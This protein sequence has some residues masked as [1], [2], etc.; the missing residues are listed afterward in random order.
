MQGRAIF[1]AITSIYFGITGP[2]YALLVSRS[3]KG[4]ET[5][6]FVFFK[7]YIIILGAYIAFNYLSN[8]FVRTGRRMATR[9]FQKHMYSSNMEL[10]LKSDNNQIE[11]LGTGQ[12]NSI[13]Q[14][15]INN[16]QWIVF[17]NLLGNGIVII[18]TIVLTFIIIILNLWRVI[19]TIVLAVFI[20][21]ITIARAG[22][23]HMKILRRERRDIMIK[24][25]RNFIRLIMSKFEILQNSRVAKEVHK[26]IDFSNQLM[27]RDKKESKWFIVASDIP[28][29]LID[30][31]KRVLLVWYGFQIFWWHWSIAEFT[32]IW[33]LMNQ[34]TGVLFNAN[35]LMLSY[36]DQIT[37]LQKLRSTFDWIPKLKWYETGKQFRFSNGEIV[38]DDVYFNYG[39]KNVFQWFSL[40][41]QW[42][43]KTAFVG[44]S[45]SGKTTLL[46]LISWYVHPDQ[47][48]VIIDGQKLSTVAL[49]DYYG[50]IWYLTQDPNVFDGSVR[51]NLLYGTSKKPTKKQIDDAIKLSRCEFIYTFKDGLETQI[52][53]KWIRLSWGQKQRLAIAKLF[54]KNPKIIFLDEPTSSLDSFSEED[55]SLAIGDLFKWR[56]VIVV[57]HRLQTVKQANIIH[58]LNKAGQIV[59]S[60]NHEELL[61]KKWLYFKMLELQS[62]F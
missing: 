31:I 17:E 14:K 21:M 2:L 54:L 28:R 58:V 16:R 37:F 5:K 47:W 32:L 51:D 60:G 20:I 46:K 13:I 59:E 23:Q 18:A 43:K 61:K 36:Y 8:Y 45:G 12:A 22:N 38:L 41:I 40:K 25:D 11:T 57:A 39:E 26:I 48:A 27:F 4:I 55:I 15:W 44:E 35:D 3:I 50:H 33:M 7:T 53:E 1:F 19:F 52:G 24:I 49:K 9:T 62:G 10:Y 42:G 34:M 29:A 30:I 56:T 6:D